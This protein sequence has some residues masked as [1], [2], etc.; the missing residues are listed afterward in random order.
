[1]KLRHI[2]ISTSLLLL[3][4]LLVL[5]Q[6]FSGGM[7]FNALKNDR[8]NLTAQQ[9]LRLQQAAL[10]S[11]WV[12]LLQTRNTLNHAATR[13]IISSSTGDT[14][15][16]A[17][18]NGLIKNAREYLARAEAHRV[19]YDALPAD[20]LHD[21]A[22]LRDITRSY[23]VYHDAL[24]EL[25][26]LLSDGQIDAYL[27]QP[28]QKY[29]DSFEQQYVRYQTLN[30]SMYQQA[31]DGSNRSYHTTVWLLSI[32]LFVMLGL[33]LITGSGIRIILS[34]PLNSLMTSIRHIADGDLTRHIDKPNASIRS[35]SSVMSTGSN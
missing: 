24:S 18:V 6:I 7:L 30:D 21:E 8:N 27:A 3:V 11:S 29:Q 5:L 2:N 14:V 25:I 35:R 20:T 13:Y 28:T 19:A 33:F 26:Q 10:N 23:T 15:G 16:G 1:M 22:V 31:V 32:T 12:A 17:S 9:T 4:G 34:R